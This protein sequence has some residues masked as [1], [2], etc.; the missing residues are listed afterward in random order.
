MAA[1]PCTTVGPVQ[2]GLGCAA[3]PTGLST[4]T[5]SSSSYRTVRPST[6]RGSTGMVAGWGMVTSSQEPPCTFALRGGV[7]PST[8]TWPASMRSA[9]AVREK[10]KSRASATSRRRPSNP[11]GT[12]SNRVSAIRVPPGPS[13]D[14]DAEGGE[15]GGQ[16]GAAHDRRV[17]QVEDRPVLAVGAEEADPVDDVS[18]KDARVAEDA[19][20]EVAQRA[21][22][23]EPE[24]DG[25]AGRAHAAGGPDD[26]DDHRDGHRGEDG[27]E[28]RPEGEGGSR[29]ARLI[30]V[31]RAAQDADGPVPLRQVGDDEDLRHDVQGEDDGGDE[32]EE[33]D[34]LGPARPLRRDG[35]GRRSVCVI[36]RHGAITGSFSR[37]WEPRPHGAGRARVSVRPSR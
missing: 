4:T 32:G 21:A 33:H 17:G 18:P 27:G 3:T 28:A 10:P 23:D 24:R 37:T 13:V 35:R 14:V 15:A 22:E 9:A 34:P 36:R 26:E 31:D 6:D 29:V 12:G 30:Q 1:R 2:P 19:I 16:D 5:R 7:E 8:L 20:G 25:P 11:S